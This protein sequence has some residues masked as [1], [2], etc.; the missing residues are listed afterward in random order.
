MAA[1]GDQTAL[2]RRTQRTGGYDLKS[3]LYREYQPTQYVATYYRQLL[4]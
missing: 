2:R 4:F 3:P 1:D